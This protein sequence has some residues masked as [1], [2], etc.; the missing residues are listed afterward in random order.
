MLQKKKFDFIEPLL[1]LCYDYEKNVF[2]LFHWDVHYGNIFLHDLKSLTTSLTCWKKSR[3]VYS[4]KK[5]CLI[6]SSG[7]SVESYTIY[8]P[9]SYKWVSTTFLDI[10]INRHNQQF[11]TSVYRKP[12]FSDVLTHYESYVD[13]TYKKS[14]ID[15]LLFR[16]FSIWCGYTSF[17]LEIKNLSEILK[18]NSYPSRIIEQSIRSFLNKLHVPK[19]VIPTVPKKELFIVLRYLG[20]LSSIQFKAKIKNLL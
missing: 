3:T 13:Q 20:T 4:P 10:K 18:K 1:W 2:V 9:N 6:S 16:C 8:F 15:T 7:I 19:K 11:K 17:H 5:T 12:I 14:L